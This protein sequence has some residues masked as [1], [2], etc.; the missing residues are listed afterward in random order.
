MRAS[1]LRDDGSVY[2]IPDFKITC[3]K[4]ICVYKYKSPNSSP[5]CLS[6]RYSIFIALGYDHSSKFHENEEHDTFDNV[7]K[8]EE[9]DGFDDLDLNDDCVI[10]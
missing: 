2:L 8:I 7:D 4:N 9:V 3:S 5:H 6:A 1:R 10:F